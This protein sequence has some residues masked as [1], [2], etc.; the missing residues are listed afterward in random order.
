MSDLGDRV[1]FLVIAG[2]GLGSLLMWWGGFVEAEVQGLRAYA[3]GGLLF[4]IF[5][6]ALILVWRSFR[7]ME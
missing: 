1:L 4:V 3:F 2:T 6:A 5:A 7:R